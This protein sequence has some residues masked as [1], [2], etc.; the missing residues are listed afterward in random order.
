DALPIFLP[1][2]AFNTARQLREVR[3][4]TNPVYIS[5]GYIDVDELV[6]E[7]PES[8]KINSRPEN[9]KIEK[10]FGSFETQLKIKDNKIIFTRKILLQEGT[11]PPE[12]YEELVNFY[13]KVHAADEAKAILVK[14]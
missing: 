1:L 4:R 13:Q 8:Y 11:Y 7:L 12:S 9:V 5:R 2:N 3:N 10:P 14:N 6:Y